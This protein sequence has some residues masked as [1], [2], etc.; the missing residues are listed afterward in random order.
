MSVAQ[1]DDY[2]LYRRYIYV[3]YSS[4]TMALYLYTHTNGV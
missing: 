2:F 1:N 3:Q 4:Q